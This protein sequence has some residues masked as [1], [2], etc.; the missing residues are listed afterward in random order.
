MSRNIDQQRATHALQSV[1]EGVRKLAPAERDEW[2]S[3]ANELPAMIQMN[4]LGSTVAF[5]YSKGKASVHRKLLNTTLKPWLCQDDQSLYPNADNLMEAI[6]NSDMHTY[7]IA[8]AEAQAYLRWV[9]KFS[10][11]YCEKEKTG[12]NS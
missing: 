8:Q 12:E 6:I 3:R 9:K 5:Y 1:K 7:Q 10:K 2:K 4:G 11:I